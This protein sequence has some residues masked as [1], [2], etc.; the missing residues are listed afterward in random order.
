MD[1]SEFPIARNT[2]AP[3]LY[4]AIMD[5][6]NLYF[7]SCLVATAVATAVCARI[8][9]ICK[10]PADYYDKPAEVKATKERIHE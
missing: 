2:A 10:E 4:N 1:T 7:F 6:W 8:Y 5:H 9:P 3:P